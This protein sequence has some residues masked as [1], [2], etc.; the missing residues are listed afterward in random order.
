MRPGD[1]SSKENLKTYNTRHSQRG[2]LSSITALELRENRCTMRK[3]LETFQAELRKASPG[4]DDSETKEETD[5][6]VE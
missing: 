4:Q 5:L 1:V 3:F 2:Y 6:R